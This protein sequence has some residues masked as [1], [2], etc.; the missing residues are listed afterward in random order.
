MPTKKW[1][2]VGFAVF[3]KSRFF[4]NFLP[5]FSQGAQGPRGD[6][7][8]TGDQGER[9]MKGHRGFSGLQGPPGPPVSI[10]N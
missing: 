3:V 2:L 4:K 9:G 5:I 7:G 10:Y 6:K 8:E 1:S